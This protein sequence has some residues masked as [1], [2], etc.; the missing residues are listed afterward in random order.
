MCNLVF[1][2]RLLC[3]YIFLMLNSQQHLFK[4]NMNF[5]GFHPF[6]S[7][8]TSKNFIRSWNLLSFLFVKISCQLHCYSVKQIYVFLN[9]WNH[10]EWTILLSLPLKLCLIVLKMYLMLLLYSM[11]FLYVLNLQNHN[12]SHINFQSH[13]YE[14]LCSRSPYS[15]FVTL[16]I[17]H[18]LSVLF[19]SMNA[20]LHYQICTLTQTSNLL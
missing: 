15:I 11:W 19:S 4:I 10:S 3:T 12:F 5:V 9:T 13:S 6:L 17:L 1:M 2:A 8:C 20:V 16:H 14:L 7:F 18:T